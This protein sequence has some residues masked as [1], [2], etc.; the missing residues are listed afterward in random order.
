MSDE[1][2]MSETKRQELRNQLSLMDEKLRSERNIGGS[3]SKRPQNRNENREMSLAQDSMQNKGDLLEI[4][5]PNLGTNESSEL[6]IREQANK[7]FSKL[8]IMC[9]SG[10]TT[11]PQDS[12]SGEPNNI[13]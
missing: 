10:G 1:K 3:I 11:T 6:Q 5:K 12:K 9:K 2:L 7:I 4:P 8:G 13:L